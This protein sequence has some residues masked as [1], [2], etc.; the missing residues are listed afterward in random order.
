[1][2][3]HDLVNAHVAHEVAHDDLVRVDVA[4]R[5]AWGERLLRGHD[6][7]DL[8]PCA[9]FRP[10]GI[11]VGYAEPVWVGCMEGGWVWKRTEAVGDRVGGEKEVSRYGGSEVEAGVPYSGLDL[12]GV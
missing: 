6:R 5:V 4:H 8:Q 2:C 3:A 7:H 9:R 12:V 1:M 10:F 11:P